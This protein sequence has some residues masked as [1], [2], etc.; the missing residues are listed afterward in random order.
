[1]KPDEPVSPNLGS[2]GADPSGQGSDQCADRSRAS[3]RAWLLVIAFGAAAGVAA[4]GVG[5]G[6]RAGFTPSFRMTPEQAARFSVGSVL[7]WTRARLREAMTKTALASYGALGAALTA[8]LG[9]AGAMARRRG[10]RGAALG[11]AGLPIGAAAA[12]AAAWA[13][14]PIYHDYHDWLYNQQRPSGVVIPML[15]QGGIVTAIGIA[16]GLALGLGLGGAGSAA[17]ASLGGALGGAIAVVCCGVLSALAFPGLET[18]Q[19]I[20][21]T[22]ALRLLAHAS[23]A[24]LIAAGALASAEHLAMRRRRPA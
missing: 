14:V 9:A 24:L 12:V 4:W 3:R 15:V 1:M 5:E 21:P 7:V 10:A 11:T 17:R 8:S 22:A 23:A 18:A 20:P 6:A 13:L 19:P 2:V 16:G